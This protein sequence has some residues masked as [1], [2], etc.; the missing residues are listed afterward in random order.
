MLNAVKNENSRYKERVSSVDVRGEFTK[1]QFYKNFFKTPMQINMCVE[2]MV[3]PTRHQNDDYGA[4]L[5]AAELMNS[6]FLRQSVQ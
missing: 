4:L 3:G 1:Q 5:I 6:V 2:S